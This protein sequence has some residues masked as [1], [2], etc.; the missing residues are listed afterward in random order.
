MVAMLRDEAPEVGRLVGTA[1]GSRHAVSPV[2]GDGDEGGG[3]TPARKLRGDRHEALPRV[4][5]RLAAAHHRDGVG[6]GEPSP[7]TPPSAH[8]AA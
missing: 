8:T 1:R 3:A 4:Q 6:E 7:A 5:S 2:A